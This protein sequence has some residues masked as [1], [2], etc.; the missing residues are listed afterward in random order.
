M[1]T[2]QGTS[3]SFGAS[4]PQKAR[5]VTSLFPEISQC[6]PYGHGGGLKNF[7][8]TTTSSITTALKTRYDHQTNISD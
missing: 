7:M 3:E 1:L 5:T 6:N 2:F 8:L 4:L